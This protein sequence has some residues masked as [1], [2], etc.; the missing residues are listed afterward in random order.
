MLKTYGTGRRTV[1]GTRSSSSL[2][3]G[4]NK[5]QL[6]PF[7][8]KVYEK[9]GLDPR[10]VM[11]YASQLSHEDMIEFYNQY[12][13]GDVQAEDKFSGR[14]GYWELPELIES[15]DSYYNKKLMSRERPEFSKC[16]QCERMTLQIS[17]ERTRAVDE[18]ATVDYWCENC[19]YK[20]RT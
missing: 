11:D 2:R 12:F 5:E 19:G 17:V 1:T 7:Q 15:V 8:K 4:A 13:N 6:T 16:P 20:K 3:L 18:A 14:V 10:I 9:E